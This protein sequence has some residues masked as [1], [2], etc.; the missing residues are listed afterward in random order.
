M[1]TRYMSAKTPASQGT[2][3]RPRKKSTSPRTT[4]APKRINVCRISVRSARCTSLKRQYHVHINMII[5]NNKLQ[6][7]QSDPSGTASALP[8]FDLDR[9]QQQRWSV[10][11]IVGRR[12]CGESMLQRELIQRCVSVVPDTTVAIASA[13]TG[14]R[15]CFTDLGYE[16]AAE[17]S[18]AQVEALVALR[19]QRR[20]QPNDT[21]SAML[22]LDDVFYT[23][24]II[25]GDLMRNVFMN[26][27][28]WK[29]KTVVAMQ[30]PLHLPPAMIT[31]VDLVFLFFEP[32]A[33]A[34][35]KM[36]KIYGRFFFRAFAAFD[37][38]MA[39]CAPDCLVLDSTNAHHQVWRFRLTEGTDATRPEI[40]NEAE[41]MYLLPSERE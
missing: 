29:I 36:Y 34:R 9:L 19:R 40:I 13:R 37:A 11:V 26:G 8:T 3:Y 15:G 22:V 6:Q 27:R 5:I 32:V 30:Y 2:P 35:L 20:Y 38:A 16:V 33:S 10:M 23:P 31:D 24:R 25:C 18:A 12:G 1:S 41:T 4:F 7:Q 14:G 39:E 17:Y 21:G 28:Y